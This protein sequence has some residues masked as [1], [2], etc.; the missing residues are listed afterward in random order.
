M[1]RIRELRQEKQLSQEELA[2]LLGV[3]RSS[4]ARWELGSNSP[5][6]DKLLALAKIFGCSLDELVQESP[7]AP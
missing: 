7:K 6:M 1:N 5:R 3:D 4:V 2:R